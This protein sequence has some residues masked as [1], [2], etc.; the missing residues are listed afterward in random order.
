MVG[1]GDIRTEIFAQANTSATADL[2]TFTPGSPVDIVG[3]GYVVTVAQAN[4]N[5]VLAGDLRPTAG[6]NTGRLNGELGTLTPADTGAQGEVFYNPLSAGAGELNPG[7]QMVIECT[8]TS[9]AT[10]SVVLF[11]RYIERPYAA[12]G[13]GRTASVVH[14]DA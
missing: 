8:T 10:G 14:V 12:E 3:W 13:E 7:Q 6:S 4:A 5:V 2:A 1:I 9:G 11:V